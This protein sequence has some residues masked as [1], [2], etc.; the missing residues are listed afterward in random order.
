MKLTIQSHALKEALRLTS[1]GVKKNSPI[2]ALQHV[3]LE[4]DPERGLKL[5]ATDYEVQITCWVACEIQAH[6]VVTL[7]AKQFT[8]IVGAASTGELRLS[9]D[10]QRTVQIASGRSRNRLFGSNPAEF[11]LLPSIQTTDGFTL[12]QWLLKDAFEKVVHAISKDENRPGMTGALLSLGSGEGR[13]AATDTHRLMLVDFAIDGCD[14]PRRAILP[15]RMLVEA[16]QFLSGDEGEEVSVRID[17][18]HV[19]LSTAF[20]CIESRL[21]AGDFPNLDK[22]IDFVHANSHGI[23]VPRLPF[24]EMLKRADILAREEA[25]RIRWAVSGSRLSIAAEAP[26]LGDCHE[27]LEIIASW[28]PEDVAIWFRADQMLEALQ[29]FDT[30]H[31]TFGYE[32]PK[33]PV[34]LYPGEA[35]YFEVLMPL[36]AP[37][38]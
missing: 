37:G 33:R 30:D 26:Q 34:L 9:S 11:P 4:T 18:S 15:K 36:V 20:H 19:E 23:T 5:T 1:R 35:R 16:I 28:N 32:S 17:E 27:E 21:I 13:L 38:D 8:E 22:V 2:P 29:V 31:V 10:E 14:K 24:M 12:Q 6:G 3:K 25:H 7:P